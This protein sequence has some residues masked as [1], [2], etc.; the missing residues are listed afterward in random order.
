MSPSTKFHLRRTIKRNKTSEADGERKKVRSHA[1][2][3]SNVLWH[4]GYFVHEAKSVFA[5][6]A[7]EAVN[8]PAHVEGS[9][10]KTETVQRCTERGAKLL[11][12]RFEWETEVRLVASWN[13]RYQWSGV[14][15]HATL[16]LYVFKRKDLLVWSLKSE[17]RRTTNRFTD[18]LQTVDHLKHFNAH[19]VSE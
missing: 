2:V 18:M 4:A 14:P 15:R 7:A 9:E 16:M 6:K 13:F 10:C 8:L 12:P 3:G 11:G 5:F 19:D 1:G 17:D